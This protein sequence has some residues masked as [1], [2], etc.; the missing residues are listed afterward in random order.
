[1]FNRLRAI[2]PEVYQRGNLRKNHVERRLLKEAMRKSYP[3][4]R[5]LI[6][7]LRNSQ[8]HE[9]NFG[10]IENKLTATCLN[11]LIDTLVCSRFY[12]ACR[13]YLRSNPHFQNK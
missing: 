13:S 3:P 5:Y 7:A 10:I 11:K 6:S 12:P 8:T 2:W 1:M 9:R 4:T